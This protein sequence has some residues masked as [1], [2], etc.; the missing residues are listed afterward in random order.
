MRDA[1]AC[2]RRWAVALLATGWAVVASPAAALINPN[3]TPVDLT[4][5]S[6]TIL[7]VELGP[8][9]VEGSFATKVL[10]ALKG[11]GPEEAFIID[12]ARSHAVERE[13]LT[14]ALREETKG[15]ALLFV[16]RPA[17]S[18]EGAKGPAAGVVLLHVRNAWFTLVRPDGETDAWLLGPDA[19]DMKAVWAGGTEMLK[20]AVEY[21]MRDPRAD[22][23]V[24]SGVSWAGR[25]R[26]G[27]LEGRVRGAR[28]VDV[29]G[30]GLP[31]LF[32]LCE[33]GDRVFR[34]DREAER[35]ADVT[36]SLGLTSQSVYA[37]WADLDGDGAL[38]LASWDGVRLAFYFAAADGRF[39]SRP[40]AAEVRRCGGLAVLDVG[41]A[42]RPGLLVSTASAPVLLVPTG[43]GAM[44]ARTLPAPG[45]GAL[46]DEGLG[47][48]LGCLVADFDGDG[49]TDVVQPFADGGLFFKGEGGGEFRA[50]AN[51]GDV[52]ADEDAR[53][54]TGDFDAD[55]LLDVM[56]TGSY[57]LYVWRNTGGGRFVEVL[58][59]S[60]EPAYIAKDNNSGGAVG[61]FNNDGRQDFLVT[62]GAGGPQLFFNRG[63]ACF[64]YAA[65]LAVVESDILPESAYGQQA[66]L[67]ADLN[68]DGAQDLTL[69]LTDGSVWVALREVT[70]RGA[71]SVSAVVPADA[72]SA[73]PVRVT[74]EA[75][76]RSRGAW[77]V[78]PGSAGFFGLRKPGACTVKWRFPGHPA[79][80]KKVF[81]ERGPVALVL[82]PD[83]A[84]VAPAR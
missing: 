14:E 53:A 22:V 48:A 66:G 70:G 34:Y 37:A 9:G 79:R 33:G 51:C 77:N 45:Q 39:T 29:D 27:A 63:F 73:G 24:R 1:R 41:V 26:L 69:V 11:H 35:F 43:G 67:L 42:G 44:S 54:Y 46:P 8:S 7:Y 71:L 76:G 38:D 75:L 3:Y 81:V 57:G 19:L 6:E 2:R 61:D 15:T 20:G 59:E 30:D 21:I 47:D 25:S 68:G 55:G 80:E 4:R 52:F 23:P 31:A 10:A 13:R 83:G 58:D 74:A 62:Y 28:A 16:G 82:R 18:A 50:P 17:E 60:G 72:G 49:L 40:V 78:T 5:Q 32:V 65:M 12:A 36:D 56:L 84:H 64:G